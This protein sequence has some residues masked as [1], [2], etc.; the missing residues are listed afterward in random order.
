M[1]DESQDYLH[2]LKMANMR[3]E[4]TALEFEEQLA[5]ATQLRE[6]ASLFQQLVQNAK[7]GIILTKADDI[8]GGPYIVYVNQAFTDITGYEKEEVI[9]KTPRMLQGDKTD[10]STL[11]EIRTA[12]ENGKSFKGELINYTK[13]GEEYWLDISI[14]PI[15]NKL[16]N[17]SHFAAIERDITD[18]KIAEKMLEETRFEAE[19]IAR[20]PINN[21]S[22]LLQVAF[23]GSVLYANPATNNLF[24]D[25]LQKGAE[26][27]FLQGIIELGQESM[28]K[29]APIA[30]EIHI[31]DII[32]QQTIHTVI[33][34]EYEPSIVVYCAD[35]TAIKRVQEDA[36]EAN[37][38]KSDFLAN[39]SHELRTPMNGILG[40]SELLIDSTLDEEQMQLVKTLHSSGNNLLQLLNDILD[41]SKV[42]AGDLKLEDVPYDTNILLQEMIQLFTPIALQQ[43]LELKFN[44]QENVPRVVVGDPA[45]L[46]Q[47]LRNLISNSL[48]F[49]EEGNVAVNLAVA[50]NELYFQVKDTG[51]GVPEDKLEMIF[52]KF[53]QADTATTRKYGGTGLGLAITKEL[54]AMM[55]GRIG[56]ESTPGFGSIFYFTVPINLA[57]EDAKPVNT[58]IENDSDELSE[59]P[60]DLKILAVDD[61]PINIFFLQK[62]LKKIG[63]I[64]VDIAEN[65]VEAVE[66]ISENDYDIVFMDCQMPELDGYQATQKIREAETGKRLPIVAMTANAMVGDREK[67]IK[68]GMDDYISKPVKI[69]KVTKAIR[70]WAM[71][72]ETTEEESA[73]VTQEANGEPVDA[74]VDLEHFRMFTDGDVEEEKMLSG[75]F[76]DQAKEILQEL[77]DSFADEHSENWRKATHKL[78][79]A[80]ANL[81]AN[82][83]SEIAQQA[84]TGFEKDESFKADIYAKIEEESNQVIKF[85]ENL[86]G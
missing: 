2:K 38:A 58:T 83:L 36:E 4:A 74:P 45:R 44:I 68:A 35:I 22:P 55:G 16:G 6:E 43:Q 62:L 60:T 34:P 10:R 27:R 54:I 5:E 46:Q 76:N 81:G 50:N 40:M 57:A 49:T 30:R 32:Y 84:E 25:L 13:T 82:R 29:D 15:K 75:M 33:S 7:D 85:L 59:I 69:E 26:H 63:L 61:H 53:A 52:E 9:G 23:D 20:F 67:C 21:P 71:N 31:D 28:E 51:I 3:A 72:T 14:V 24:P 12:L 1:S 64:N 48:K 86:H 47:I 56:V 78:K 79:G 11:N 8:N 42:E 77:K 17:I 80:S 18:R 65:G 73:P 37:K 41:I 19:K 66:K 70:K 39:M